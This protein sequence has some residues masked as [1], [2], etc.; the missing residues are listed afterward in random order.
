MQKNT[1]SPN[2]MIVCAII[3]FSILLIAGVLQIMADEEKP[4]NSHIRSV[5][6]F[7]NG[8]AFVEEEIFID[9]AGNYLWTKVPASIHGSFFIESDAEV[10]TQITQREIDAPIEIS[11]MIRFQKDLAGRKVRL[12]LVRGD[13]EDIITGILRSFES[14]EK[15]GTSLID[16]TTGQSILPTTPVSYCSSV[17]QPPIYSAVGNLGG[18]LP[19]II[20]DTETG[21]QI[22]SSVLVQ[23]V[24][25]LD[26]IPFTTIK[27]QM[28][29]MLFSV[30]ESSGK[31]GTNA[32]LN[33]K[34]GDKPNEK[35]GQTS[36]T[37]RISYLTK[38]LC[39]MP[40]Y[41]VDIVDSKRLSIEQNA[42][43]LN[44]WDNLT[45]TEVALISG[46][47]Q[48]EFENSSSP[49]DPRISLATF[50]QSLA[51]R[52]N[53]GH[54]NNHIVTQQAVMFNSFSPSAGTDPFAD[55]ASG[56][57]ASAGGEGPDTFF[58]S[59]GPRSLQK[60]DSLFLSTGKGTAN[61]ERL[62]Y[63]N[64]LDS[65]DEWGRTIDSN[66]YNNS[67][68]YGRTTSGT[69]GNDSNRQ[70]LEPWDILRFKNPFPFPMTTAPAV[71]VGDGKFYG[72]NTSFWTNPD[73]ETLLPVT[74]SLSVRV[75]S[76]ETEKDY[77]FV[78]TDS[79]QK[80][81]QINSETTSP[82]STPVTT[83]LPTS[84][85]PVATPVYSPV[86]TAFTAPSSQG[87]NPPLPIPLIPLQHTSFRPVP[88]QNSVLQLTSASGKAPPQQMSYN[89]YQYRLVFVETEITITNQRQENCAMLIRRQISGQLFEGKVGDSEMFSESN[90]RPENK[91]LSPTD[92]MSYVNRRAELSWNIVLAPGETKKL[93][94]LHS[95]WV[96]M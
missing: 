6:V 60:G 5:G 2:K 19:Q 44:E 3:S 41:R 18:I 95:L 32:K 65:R 58:Q 27:K 31:L 77:I 23:R 92:W 87:L 84:I 70:F 28:P 43:L 49:M 17:Y 73:E 62:I 4:V 74:K 14:R 29:V 59:I 21:T 86:P 57:V 66:S 11:D 75:K 33:D 46:F 7:K 83:P 36:H 67:A 85:R 22:L 94:T 20:I 10:E 16:E 53:R 48:I 1:F 63:W 93:T 13:S 72:Q 45:K 81:G 24:E 55:N 80:S 68:S 78:S 26:D 40:S 82:F 71:V 30:K 34:L 54:G 90:P 76:E 91:A 79:E 47:P 15:Q 56:N 51:N 89:G 35:N 37:I 25:I 61:Y 50:F 38:G 12:H 9:A 96:R 52:N 39:W 69:I 42:L 64:I 88:G 8:V